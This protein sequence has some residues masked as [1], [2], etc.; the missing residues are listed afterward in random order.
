[1]YERLTFLGVHVETLADGPV[2]EIH[3]GLKG[4]MSALP[5]KDL[6][7][8]TRRGQMG[9]VKA[10]RIPGGK[11][12]SYDVVRGGDERGRRTIN[13]DEATI[14]QR[15]FHESSCAIS[16]VKASPGHAAD[17]GMFRPCSDRRSVAMAS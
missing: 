12:Y 15:I 13:P 16:M 11:S 2:S 9:H 17:T 10:G 1:M 14:V 4:T 5:L 3:V 8:K 7:Q 6:A